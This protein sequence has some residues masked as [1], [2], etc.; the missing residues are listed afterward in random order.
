MI[1]MKFKS[2]AALMAIFALFGLAQACG[3]YRVLFLESEGLTATE[4]GYVLAAGGL[5]AALARPLT[6]ALADKL[7]SRR[8]VY[9]GSVISW[10][11]LLLL[12]LITK[13]ARIATFVLSAGIIP[14][15]SVSDQ[16]TYGMLEASGVNA[17]VMNPKLDFSLIRVCLSIGYCGINFLYTPIVK[18]FGPMAPFACTLVFVVVLLLSSGCLSHFETVEESE[19]QQGRGKRLE[20]GRLF[21]NYYLVVF[22]LLSLIMSLGTQTSSYVV[23]LIEALDMDTALVGLAAG[24][25]VLGEILVM[26]MV[27]LLKRRISLPMLQVVAGLFCI[28][29]M[30][31]FLTCKNP[32]MIMASIALSGVAYAITL[33]TTAV[34]LRAMAPEGLDTTTLS[35]TTATSSLSMVLMS[36]LGGRIIDL[37]GIFALYR[38]TLGLLCLWIILYFS[39]WAFG[40]HV[41]KKTPPVSMFLR[42]HCE[43]CGKRSV[44]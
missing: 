35:L 43:Q 23:F 25:R 12:L 19:P 7:H 6:G 32:Y 26:L 10:I 15:L 20:V 24:I 5:L 31:V 34:Y 1:K 2:T 38:M 27:P 30:I 40:V 33:S 13:H 44:R 21:Q 16:V 42:R 11:A 18:R 39:T 3:E 9:V 28:L 22:V 14:L 29:Q 8:I 4:C 37:Y 41:L 17:T 36:I